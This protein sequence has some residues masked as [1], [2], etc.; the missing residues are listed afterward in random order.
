[1]TTGRIN[2]VA[3]SRWSWTPGPEGPEHQ[4]EVR[5][6]VW[7]FDCVLASVS[8]L[9]CTTAPSQRLRP[10]V[11]TPWRGAAG[12]TGSAAPARW[13][14]IPP[15]SSAEVCYWVRVTILN[16]RLQN[17]HWS[18]QLQNKSTGHPEPESLA[19]SV[20]AKKEKRIQDSLIKHLPDVTQKQEEP[21]TGEVAQSK[22]RKNE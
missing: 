21:A 15:R 13:N 20:K 11:E 4:H 18:I 6:W 22:R 10:Q 7:N 16:G 8:Q 17:N 5:R 2:Q 12:K 3:T 14:S 1:M 9:S 19:I